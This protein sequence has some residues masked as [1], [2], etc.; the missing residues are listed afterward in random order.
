MKALKVKPLIQSSSAFCAPLAFSS[1]R[2]K[3]HFAK[4]S[5][6]FGAPR[7]LPD[8][9]GHVKNCLATELES[10]SSDPNVE[11]H[12]SWLFENL[13]SNSMNSRL[14][15]T[16]E[17]IL[18]PQNSEPEILRLYDRKYFQG[19]S[20]FSHTVSVLNDIRVSS[21]GAIEHL[22]ARVR[23]GG[24]VMNQWTPLQREEFQLVAA[25]KLWKLKLKNES[26]RK[27]HTEY[28]TLWRQ[29]LNMEPLVPPAL[30]ARLVKALVATHTVSMNELARDH[31]TNWRTLTVIWQVCGRRFPFEHVPSSTGRAL[32]HIS[33]KYEPLTFAYVPPV[34]LNAHGL[35][36]SAL[37]AFALDRGDSDLSRIIN[38]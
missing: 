4:F 35:L 33:V 20:T 32:Q 27:L 19:Q 15:P 12:F 28:T 26:V 22:C 24:T 21:L 14:V 10:K 23:R 2:Y 36:D 13:D 38:A 18:A 37:R 6:K 3:S 17:T 5:E 16:L 11:N 8:I 1:R 31:I 29:R 7:Q 9:S 34:I 25:N 30:V